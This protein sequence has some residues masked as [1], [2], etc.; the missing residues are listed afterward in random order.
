[1]LPW[2]K[3]F[4]WSLHLQ[5]TEILLPTEEVPRA[6]S[7]PHTRCPPS[8][9]TSSVIIQGTHHVS[10]GLLHLVLLPQPASSRLTLY[11]VNWMTPLGPLLLRI[12]ACFPASS[13]YSPEPF[14]WHT[15]RSPAQPLSVCQSHLPNFSQLCP[16]T[17]VPPDLLG[18]PGLRA[19]C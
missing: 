17:N 1:M 9:R 5:D 10:P 15:R 16:A 14:A 13:A 6:P 3:H 12:P 2:R 19:F 11:S 8:A 4:L 18:L 7:Q